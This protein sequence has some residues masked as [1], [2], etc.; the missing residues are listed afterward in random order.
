MANNIKNIIRQPT[1]LLALYVFVVFFFVSIDS[2]THNL[3]GRSESAFLFTGG[4]AWINGMIPYIDFSAPVGPLLWFIYG[5]GYIISPFDYTGIFWLSA[6]IYILIYYFLYKTA[7]IFLPNEPQSMLCAILLAL[8]LFNPWFHNEMRAEQWA[9]LFI[10]LSLYRACYTIYKNLSSK[11]TKLTFLCFGI[12][13]SATFLIDISIAAMLCS[14]PAL[15][16][17]YILRTHAHTYTA[18]GYFTIGM[19]IVAIPVALVMLWL[20][21]LS[22]FYHE[23]IWSTANTEWQEFSIKQYIHD[24]QMTFAKPA[25]MALFALSIIGTLLMSK[26]VKVYPFFLL[27]TFIFFYAIAICNGRSNYHISVC[28][29]FPLY[30]FIGL[31][32]QQRNKHQLLPPRFC[33]FVTLSIFTITVLFNYTY[34]NGYALNELIFTGKHFAKDEGNDSD[35]PWVTSLF[36]TNSPYKDMFDKMGGRMAQ[37]NKPSVVYV[38]LPDYGYGILA[39][40]LPGAKYWSMQKKTGPNFIKQQ[41]KDIQTGKPD[42]VIIDNNDSTTYAQKATIMDAGYKQVYAYKTRAHFFSLLSKH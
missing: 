25:R 24:W 40:V 31:F 22:P 29:I 11:E 20:D 17:I 42:F 38:G 1:T 14:I 26:R 37:V 7:S 35:G 16:F 30:F 36:F 9:Q 18:I 8:F 6:F 21:M 12:S 33:V 32:L 4:K 2:Y 19:L 41:I 39:D 3:I 34:T 5:I 28:S 15:C 10:T 27:S 13:I 23:Y